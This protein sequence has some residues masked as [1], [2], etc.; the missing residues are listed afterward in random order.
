MREVNS[1]ITFNNLP[2]DC[3]IFIA[4]SV[5]LAKPPRWVLQA[6]HCLSGQIVYHPMCHWPLLVYSF[7]AHLSFQCLYTTFVIFSGRTKNC[8]MF[9]LIWVISNRFLTASV[10]NLHFLPF[11][12][13]GMVFD[14][15]RSSS[16]SFYLYIVAT[17][18]IQKSLLFRIVTYDRIVSIRIVT[19]IRITL[20]RIISYVRITSIRIITYMRIISNRIIA[21]NF[22]LL[23]IIWCLSIT[24][25]LFRVAMALCFR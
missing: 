4:L 15:F 8:I 22:S 6:R 23:A 7:V 25:S 13:W 10:L 2:F 12:S 9:S 18:F 21:Y 1:K 14:C 20:I 5:V 16:S 19:Y 17:S 24:S 3:V 11:G